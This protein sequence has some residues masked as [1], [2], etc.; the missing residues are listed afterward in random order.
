MENFK[1]ELK[2]ILIAAMC[3]GCEFKLARCKGQQCKSFNNKVSA[4]LL[5]IEKVVDHT[6][7]SQSVDLRGNLVSKV[8]K[9]NF[10]IK[11]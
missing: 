1:Q 3:S 6:F 4:I 9:E 7:N 2:G 10:G 11:G 5:E 8:L